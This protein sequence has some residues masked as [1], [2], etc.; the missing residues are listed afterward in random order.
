MAETA[1][2]EEILGNRGDA[3]GSSAG[4]VRPAA[5]RVRW[6]WTAL[7]LVALVV[8]L[9]AGIRWR[10][11][12]MP[13][14]RDEGEYAYA[15][16]LILQ[17]IPPYEIAYNMKLP[18]T[19]VAYAA[20]LRTFGETAAGIHV[21]LLLV[22]GCATLLLFFLGRQLYGDLAGVTAAASYAL[23]STTEGVLGLAGHAT[24]FVVLMAVAGLLFLLSARKSKNPAA[25]FA[26]GMCMG[27]AFL[28]K[29]PGI[30]FVIFGAQ[31]VAWRGL[32][33][34]SRRRK[35]AMRLFLYA[36]GAAIPYLLTCAALYRAGVFEKF[37]FWTVSYARQYATSTDVTQGLKY[38]REVAPDLF[39]GA[40]VVWCFAAIGLL[41]LIMER[42]KGAAL[43]FTVGLLCWS[44]VGASAGLYYR[45]HYF[46][47][48]L[49]AVCLLAGKAMA[50]S[51][52]QLARIVRINRF[53]LRTIGVAVFA[54]GWAQALYAQR[55]I[56]FEMSPE[57][58][59]RQEYGGNPFP[60]AIEFGKYIK[61]HSDLDARI[62][63]LGSEPEIYFYAQRHSATGYIYTYGLM[64]EQKFASQMQQ[65]MIDEIEKA[66]PEYLVK[67]MVPAS[68]LRKAN[69]DTAILYWAEKYIRD[70]YRIVGVADVARE[71]SYHWDDAAEGYRP[72]S[73]YSV[74]LY[75]RK[76]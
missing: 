15:G 56:F 25:Y 22:N 47:L 52:E 46:I 27:L 63:V 26:A 35:L 61:E 13:L 54:L 40:P 41:A 38:L 44:F 48:M 72:L 50:W 20:I 14:E 7:T 33:Q 17:G 24:H 60:E 59:V 16:Q 1:E 53:R 23:L 43:S 74:Y 62:A 39:F 8:L 76:I 71:T 29:Q 42:G 5:L 36:M 68:W 45:N 32:K 3:I 30:V 10:L 49:P 37:W 11:R 57:K 9:F 58:I 28:M 21:G 65:E 34:S 12:E 2:Q 31:E 4:W 73:K 18:G 64:E 67:V 51:V 19:Y 6:R 66:K 70:N 75:K 69:S 55:A